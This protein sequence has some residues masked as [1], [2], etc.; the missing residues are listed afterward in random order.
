MKRTVV[1]KAH[2]AVGVDAQATAK[3]GAKGEAHFNVLQDAADGWANPAAQLERPR[4]MMAIPR[5]RRR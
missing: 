4:P 1:G 2:L 3:V 5:K